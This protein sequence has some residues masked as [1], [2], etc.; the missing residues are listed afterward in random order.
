MNKEIIVNIEE[1]ERRICFLENGLLEEF[2]LERTGSQRLTGNIY[3]GKVIKVMPGIEAA[4]VNIGHRKNGFLHISD[5]IEDKAVYE[6]VAGEELEEVK[7]PK[8]KK[9]KNIEDYLEVD[10]DIIVQIV[11]DS[12][13]SKGPRLSTNISLPGKYVVLLPRSERRGISRRISDKKARDSAMKIARELKLPKKMGVIMRTFAHNKSYEECAEDL[14]LLK[15]LWRRVHKKYRDAKKPGL[16]HP[17]K[18]L[19]KRIVRDALTDDVDRVVI[20]SKR[21]Y[22]DIRKYLSTYLP[23][24]QTRVQLYEGEAPIFQT[25]NLEK[26]IEK[27]Y[28]KKI[29]LKCGGYIVIEQT[30]A[31]VAIDVNTGR[32]MGKN[33]VEKTIL[34]TNIEAAWEISRQLRLRNMGGIIIID[35]IDMQPRQN[36]KKLMEEL[37][38]ALERDKART[39]VLPV[40]EIGLVQMT[41]ERDKESIG[42][43]VTGECPY[44][45]GMGSIKDVESISI[46]IQRE[47]RK[48][49][50]NGGDQDVKVCAHPEVIEQLKNKHGNAV[51]KIVSKASFN[52][53]FLPVADYHLEEWNCLKSQ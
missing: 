37:L 50:N 26:E 49:A 31:L 34:T 53:E 9:K 11:K 46:D 22:E 43:M 38:K 23:K 15:Y 29:W 36:Q 14:K 25:Y 41:R 51:K 45:H 47:L 30:E 19:L 16:I 7:R 5:I 12:I 35:F 6:E 1:H 10:D 28:R 2:Y 40:S 27:A 44:C 24:S 52:V 18:D 42:E 33:D 21:E 3:R 4:F 8:A 20:D 39:H 13:G 32:H 17:E 48:L